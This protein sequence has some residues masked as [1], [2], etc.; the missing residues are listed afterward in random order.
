MTRQNCFPQSEACG[1]EKCIRATAWLGE[2]R[3]T[4]VHKINEVEEGKKVELF[5]RSAER[6]ALSEN[7]D[8]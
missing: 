5:S 7:R 2:S 3:T 4:R 6:I 1:F 8:I